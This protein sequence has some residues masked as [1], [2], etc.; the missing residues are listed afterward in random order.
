VPKETTTQQSTSAEDGPVAT[1][2]LRNPT[3][4]DAAEVWQLVRESGVLDANSCYVYLL[5]CEHFSDTCVV[6]LRGDDLVGFVTAY[7]LPKRPD[8]LFVWQVGVDVSARRQ[9]LGKTL[10]D[11][12]L[13]LPACQGIRFVEATV[14]P[15]NQA[16]R[17]LFE[18][19]ARQRGASCTWRRGFVAAD[20][21]GSSHEDEELVRLGPFLQG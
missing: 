12:L 15:S 2:V 6:A 16:S 1:V 5:L 18:S 7:R 14:A 4:A 13:D 17:R 3:V 21:G 20:F 8:V 9:G 10:L 19:V 11:H